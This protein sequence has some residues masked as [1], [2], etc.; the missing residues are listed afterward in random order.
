MAFKPVEESHGGGLL[1]L[2]AQRS[3]LNAQVFN[4]KPALNVERSAL[5]LGVDG[6]ANPHL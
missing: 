2:N 3:T 6:E 5:S 1:T 4:R